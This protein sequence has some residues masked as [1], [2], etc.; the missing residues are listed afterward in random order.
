MGGVSALLRVGRSEVEYCTFVGWR[1]WFAGVENMRKSDAAPLSNLEIIS[2]CKWGRSFAYFPLS[3]LVSAR[4]TSLAV[5]QL[6]VVDSGSPHF[7]RGGKCLSQVR[8]A[9]R[10]TIH[11]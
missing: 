8:A 9:F 11:G 1:V 7:L 2:Y 3:W 5:A 10:F 6:R 4:K